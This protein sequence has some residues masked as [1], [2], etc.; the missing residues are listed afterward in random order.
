MIIYIGIILYSFIFIFSERASQYIARPHLVTVLLLFLFW[1]VV[2]GGLYNKKHLELFFICFPAHKNVLEYM[3]YVHLFL[4]PLINLIVFNR[5]FYEKDVSNYSGNIWLEFETS[6]VSEILLLIICA[7]GEE[8]FFRGIL[9]STL[10]KQFKILNCIIVVSLIFAFLHVSNFDVMGN[11][12]YVL[13]QC[14]YAGVIGFCFAVITY[15][16]RSIFLSVVIHVLMN[17]SSFMLHEKNNFLYGIDE[18]DLLDFQI[19]ISIILLIIYLFYGI[20]MYNVFIINDGL[21]LRN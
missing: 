11:F 4:L 20:W 6:R 2:L 16:D 10:I 7:V 19:I 5:E 12:K 17:I 8:I 18:F 3:I 1:A 14:L 13:I 9:L 15:R 21:T